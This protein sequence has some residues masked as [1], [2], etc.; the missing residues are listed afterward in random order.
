MTPDLAWWGTLVG[1]LAVEVAALVALGAAVEICVRAPQA[2]RALWQGV[3][4][5]VALIWVAEISGLPEKMKLMYSRNQGMARFNSS[6]QVAGSDKATGSGPAVLTASENALTPVV[7]AEFAAE[8]EFT[9]ESLGSPASGPPPLPIPVKWP[10]WI[11]FCGT[12]VLLLRLA[13]A[14]GCLAIQRRRIPGSWGETEGI[15]ARLLRQGNGWQRTARPT[16]ETGEMVARLRRPLGLRRVSV[17]VWPG[18]RGPIAFGVWRPTVA[19]PVDFDSRFTPSQR[20]A[21]LAHELAHLAACDP[22]WLALA[23][24]VLAVAWWHPAVWWARRRLRVAGEAAADEASALVPSGPSALAE[25]LVLFGRELAAP[26]LTRGLGV[27]GSGFRSD[28]SRR[29][30]ALLTHSGVWNRLSDQWRWSPRLAALGIAVT[31][32]MA[33]ARAGFSGSVLAALSLPKPASEAHDN[34]VAGSNTNTDAA[35]RAKTVK[36]EIT[37]PSAFSKVGELDTPARPSEPDSITKIMPVGR[38][39]IKRKLVGIRVSEV[40]FDNVALKEVLKNLSEFAIKGDPDGMGINFMINSR[41]DLTPASTDPSV[42]PSA[43]LDLGAVLIKINPPLHDVSLGNVLDAVCQVADAPI[44]YDIEDFAVVFVPKP[45]AVETLITR[46]FRVDSNTFLQ[47]VQALAAITSAMRA[48]PNSDNSQRILSY[49]RLTGGEGFVSAGSGDNG[50]TIHRYTR[51]MPSVL[52]TNDLVLH[53]TIR[54]YFAAAG[55][56]LDPPKTLFFNERN[57]ILMVRVSEDEIKIIRDAI[58][59]LLDGSDS[60]LPPTTVRSQGFSFNKTDSDARTNLVTRL[61]RADPTN[62]VQRL[63][64]RSA[65]KPGGG[66]D[67]K[68]PRLEVVTSTNTL[69][70]NE[71][72]REYF[73]SAGASLD[74]PKT[75]FFNDRKGILMVRATEDDINVIRSAIDEMLNTPATN[76]T[77]Q[78]LGAFGH[79]GVLP[80][81]PDAAPVAASPPPPHDARVSAPAVTLLVRFTFLPEQSSD[82]LGLDWLFGQSPTNNPAPRTGPATE[83]LQTTNLTH[84]EN[85]RI[86]ALRTEGQSATLTEAQFRVLLHTLEEREGVDVL[87]APTIKTLSGRRARIEIRDAH[88]IVSAVEARNGVPATKTSASASYFTEKV[89][90]GSMLDVTPFAEGGSWRLTALAGLTEFL[91]YDHPGK[92]DEIKVSYGDAKPLYVQKPLPHFRSLEARASALLASGETLALRGPSFGVTNKIKG[93]IFR[94]AKTSVSRKRLYIF[95]TVLPETPAP[96]VV[97]VGNTPPYLSVN[98]KSMTFEEVRSMM[99]VEVARNPSLRVQINSGR[100][101]PVGEVLKVTKAAREANIK[102]TPSLLVVPEK[103]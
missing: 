17:Q 90:T 36:P 97:V 62:L 11:W 58:N 93:G 60:N 89:S 47:G 64:N 2:R 65:M 54:D 8:E 39:V 100:D 95:V 86:D 23:D 84:T 33:P 40:H 35:T 10:G 43:P 91:G 92:A 38:S 82:E 66:A 63:R 44:T 16:S 70:V 42:P 26:A 15:I 41:V 24:A 4:I 6:I 22:F 80:S 37:S 29:V 21:M 25:S 18:L 87:S 20:H 71:M 67:T 79:P 14:W 34:A 78:A 68:P 74:P 45:Q 96:L 55:V 103:N 48:Q 94:K 76:Q 101:A 52:V 73:I 57:G 46:T 98:A 61:F 5:A 13:V 88:T 77:P 99:Q 75:V 85:F 30:S 102:I 3:L 1:R 72:V 12:T 9:G 53:Q 69:N 31:L 51:P 7:P 81:T 49:T 50:Q 32:A 27:A 19:L 28:L 56:N 59:S 83:L